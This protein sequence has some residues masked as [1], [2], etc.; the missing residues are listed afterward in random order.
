M[1]D[2]AI[3]GAGAAGIEAVK[4]SLRKRLKTVL[5]D[6][7]YGNFGGTCLNKGCVPAKYYLSSSRYNK[8]I[9]A[10]YKDKDNIVEMIKHSVLEYIKKQGADVIW[11]TLVL[12]QK[13]V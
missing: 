10:I 9:A 12:R 3:I 2:V 4:L 1:Y 6:K 7:D 8:D 11:S 5:I 13:I